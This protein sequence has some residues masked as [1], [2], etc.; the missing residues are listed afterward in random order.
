MPTSGCPDSTVYAAGVI[1][2]HLLMSGYFVCHEVDVGLE[3]SSEGTPLIRVVCGGKRARYL[4][5]K[6]G[7]GVRDS[8][9]FRR[10]GDCQAYVLLS[11]MVCTM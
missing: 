3:C 6:I 1:D 11:T 10:Y 2:S 5:G 8:Q 4:S 9:C 7:D